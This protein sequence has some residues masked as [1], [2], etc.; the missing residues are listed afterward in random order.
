MELQLPE[1]QG[2]S[3]REDPSKRKNAV[4]DRDQP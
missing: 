1:L 2:Y 4:V 3:R